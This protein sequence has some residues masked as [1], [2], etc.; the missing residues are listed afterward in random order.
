[1]DFA[2]DV[3]GNVAITSSSFG[4]RLR[5]A[6]GEAQ[7]EKFL[8]AAGQAFSLMTPAKRE[9]SMW[10]SDQEITQ[11]VDTNYVAG[12]VWDR[13]PQVRFTL[14]PSEGWSFAIA[15]ENP[16][17][18]LGT[19]VTLPQDIRSDIEREFNTGTNQLAIPNLMPDLVFK[20]AFNSGRFHVD[21]GGLLRVFRTSLA[22]YAKSHK[23]IAGGGNVN[24]RFG[25]T[26]STQLLAQGFMSSGGGRY[27]GGLVPDA[28]V[29]PDGTVSPLRAHSWVSGIEQRASRDVSLALYYSG[30]FAGRQFV[31]DEDGSLIGWGYPGSPNSNNRL[32]HQLTA[33]YTWRFLATETRGSGQWNFQYS[34][35]MRKPWDVGNGSSTA[36]GNMFL[37]QIRYNLP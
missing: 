37:T 8:L 9:I 15:A 31:L 20:T 22:P 14:R 32:L 28:I 30:F 19:N 7:Y 16:E 21:V 10:P 3:P 1:M 34:Y 25:L 26:A 2:G 24:F 33:L 29:R 12:L 17:Q 18:Q 27:I 6:F 23:Q 13:A 35:L 11:A 5:H 4:F 36:F